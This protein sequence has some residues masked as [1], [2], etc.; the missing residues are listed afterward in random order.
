MAAMDTQLQTIQSGLTKKTE[1]MQ[2]ST[3]VYFMGDKAED[4]LSH[5]T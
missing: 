2:V 4:L 1:N 5:L 3:L